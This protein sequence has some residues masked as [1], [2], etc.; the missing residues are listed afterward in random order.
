MNENEELELLEL[1][2]ELSALR[3]A[4]VDAGLLARM[5]RGLAAD[6]RRGRDQGRV[7]QG[8]FARYGQVAAAAL[9]VLSSGLLFL[10]T[11]SGGE[12]QSGLVT[13]GAANTTATA[14][15]DR[16]QRTGGTTTVSSPKDGGLIID[17]G[18][19][20][21]VLEYDVQEEQQWK[22]AADGSDV[23]I[24]LPKKEQMRIPIP[25]F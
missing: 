17:D 9:L 13:A 1:E 16:F 8:F 4:A 12:R 2:A 6:A 19:P 11:K 24:K 15:R 23:R 20:F 25:V 14:S 22:N 5:E 18:R 7:V 3:P 10:V 21:Q